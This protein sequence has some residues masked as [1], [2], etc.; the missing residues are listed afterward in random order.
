MAGSGS[1]WREILASLTTA[2]AERFG[3]AQRRGRIAPGMDAD[4]AVQAT[5]AA[6]DVKAFFN[7][8]YTSA[9]ELFSQRSPDIQ[10]GGCRR[11]SFVQF[12]AD[13]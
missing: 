13:A 12:P 1:D 8:R 7:V 9:A 5:D 2:P 3:E 6:I 10:V 11:N 4:V